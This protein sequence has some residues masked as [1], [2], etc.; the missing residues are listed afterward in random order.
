MN[1][2]KLEWKDG[3]CWRQVKVK[4][5]WSRNGNLTFEH[6][7]CRYVLKNL[8]EGTEVLVLQGNKW[9][10]A[11]RIDRYGTIVLGLDES[12]SE[13][14]DQVDAGKSKELMGEI[15]S[16]LHPLEC[17]PLDQAEKTLANLNNAKYQEL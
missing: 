3:D 5:G 8:L 9:V 12:Y 4:L 16:F 6:M 1:Q 13:H 10:K 14:L 7:G 17:Q 15:K 2:R 11:G